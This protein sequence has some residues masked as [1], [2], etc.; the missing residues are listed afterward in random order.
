MPKIFSSFLS[1]FNV[2]S[3]KKKKSHHA[4]GGIFFSDF[5][6]ISKKKKVLRLSSPTFLRDFCD[7]PER[8]AVNRSCLRFLAGNKNASFWLEKKRR[9][10]Q[11][12]SAKMPEKISHFSHFFALTG[13]TDDSIANKKL[14]NIT[15][16]IPL[17]L[18]AMR[19]II[20]NSIKLDKKTV[21]LDFTWI[22][23]Q[24]GC[25]KTG[26]E[27]TRSEGWRPS[28]VVDYVT[29]AFA[30]LREWLLIFATGCFIG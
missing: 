11:N 19:Y 23:E 1:S 17:H 7:I 5:M 20:E 14:L 22:I 28:R 16:K 8:N 9:N 29:R 2:I 13:N 6:L 4:D 18:Y 25:V 24:L 3:K 12:F 21:F 10:S 15:K 27:A 26:R 30:S